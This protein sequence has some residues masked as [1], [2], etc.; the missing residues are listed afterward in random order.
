[1]STALRLVFLVAL[2]VAVAMVVLAPRQV[3]TLKRRVLVV[4][5]SFIAAILISAALRLF[6][7][8]SS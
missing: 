2:V 6:V 1:M 5:Y 3:R 4:G 7:L 8:D